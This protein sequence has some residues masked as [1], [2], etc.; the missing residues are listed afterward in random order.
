MSDVFSRYWYVRSDTH[1]YDYD[2]GA[3]EIDAGRTIR[4]ETDL[5]VI[6]QWRGKLFTPREIADAKKD[7]RDGGYGDNVR[8]V[9]VT[10]YQ[11]AS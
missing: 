1:V 8:A 3:V 11:K 5:D 10:V 4:E 2:G 7:L 9:Q 6:R